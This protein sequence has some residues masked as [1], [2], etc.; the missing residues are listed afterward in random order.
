MS[1]YQFQYFWSKDTISQ[2]GF[3]FKMSGPIFARKISWQNRVI[4]FRVTC[5]TVCFCKLQKLNKQTVI[6]QGQFC[7][8]AIC[9]LF[10]I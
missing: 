3:Y 1:L 7:C 2:L 9:N 8:F 5:C 10:Q 6:A 4:I